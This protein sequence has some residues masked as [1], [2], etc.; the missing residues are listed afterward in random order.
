LVEAAAANRPIVTT[1]VTG[2]R[3]VVRDGVEGFLVPPGDEEAAARALVTLAADPALRARFGA[4]ARAR[5]E[6]RFTVE[7]VQQKVRALYQSLSGRFDDAR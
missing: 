7:A 4:A 3:E 6:E 1:D 2:C 5:F